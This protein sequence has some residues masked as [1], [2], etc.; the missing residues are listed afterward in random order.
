MSEAKH[1]PGPLTVR[2]RRPVYKGLC[3]ETPDAKVCTAEVYGT[4]DSRQI[5]DAAWANAYLYAAAP[6]LLEALEA[7][8][9]ERTGYGNSM[10]WQAYSEAIKAARAALAKA[11]GG[12]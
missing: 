6:D 2:L 4:E 11:K 9:P 12:A 8:M 7:F 5:D 10:D 3:I 1:T